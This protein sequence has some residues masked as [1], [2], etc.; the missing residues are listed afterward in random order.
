MSDKNLES[1]VLGGG[2][3]WCLEATYSHTKGVVSAVSG[4]AGGKTANP[5]YEQVSSG[6]TG[7]AEVTKI[8]FD[9]SVI[10]LDDILHIFFLIHNPT[11]PDRQGN[12]IGTQYRSVI[13]Y[14]TK[15]Q[16]DV[17]EK[18]M[19]ELAE[20]RVYDQPIVTEL[21]PLKDFYPAEEYHQHYFA[22]NPD[23]A[24]CQAVIAPKLA[25]FRQKYAQFYQ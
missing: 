12:D 7:H 6:A 23:Q 5:T 19:K 10:T 2:C 9:P 22:K 20:E 14:H 18:I 24:Y 25:K 8:T 16:Y 1:I 17:A 4:Y 13:Y 21:Y 11:T 15:E 3:F